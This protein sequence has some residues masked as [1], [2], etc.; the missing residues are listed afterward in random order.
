MERRK[1]AIA[2]GLAAL[3]IIVL[4]AVPVA[5]ISPPKNGEA[6]NLERQETSN[7]GCS[8]L[9]VAFIVDQSWAMEAPG[10]QEATDPLKQRKF[11]VDAMIDLL[12]G[13]S[14]DQCPGTHHR[15]T[16]VSYGSSV[17]TN[18]SLYDINPKTE[19]DAN[20]LRKEEGIKSRIKAENM[21]SGNNPEAAFNEVYRIWRTAPI[22]DD[23]DHVTKRVIVFLTNGISKKSPTD[24]A[25]GTESVKQQV[26]A[27]FPFD[28]VLLAREQCLNASR[29]EEG[30]VEE[31]AAAQCMANHMPANE[32][33]AYKNS[34]YIWTVFLKPPGYEKY[35]EAYQKIINHYDEMSKTHAGE[36]VELRA[37]SRKDIPTTFR[38]ILSYLAGVRPVLLNCGSFAMNPYLREARITVYKIDPEIKITLSYKDQDGVTHSIT[39]GK[40]DSDSAFRVKNYYTFGANEAYFLSYPYAGIWEL[41]ADNCQGLDTYYEQVQVNTSQKLSLP[42]II[43]QYEVEPFYDPEYPQ[44]LTYEMHD[45]ETGELILQANHPRFA[46]KTKADV[47][48]PTGETREYALKWDA[49]KKAFVASEPLWV[50]AAG[51]YNVHITGVSYAR[52]DKPS[53]LNTVVPELVFDK[54]FTLFEV[55]TQFEVG[56][57]V[58]F[59]IEIVQ[60]TGKFKNVH[61]LS[62]DRYPPLLVAP[63]TVQVR[64]LDRDKNM[65]PKPE[66]YLKSTQGVFTAYLEGGEKTAQVV[67][68][69]DPQNPGY[70]TGIAENFDAVGA[71]T[72][73]V[74]M[75][76]DAMLKDRRPYNREV[77]VEFERVD[78]LFHTP[79]FWNFLAYAFAVYL[80]GAAIVFFAVR[81]NKVNGT[82]AFED[83]S[84]LIAEFNLYSGKNWRDIKNRELKNQSQLGLKWMRISN[85]PR[86]KS[87]PVEGEFGLSNSETSQPGI[88]VRGARSDGSKFDF[89]LAPNLPTP[90]NESTI[91]MTYQPVNK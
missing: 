84:A 57:V 59:T 52:E 5:A 87:R 60:P 17:K 48:A 88:R 44:Y 63:M 91:T 13:L 77:E 76:P 69:P 20:E 29:D 32:A 33:E 22:I 78:D 75:N 38:K 8:N 71:Q 82:L 15:I 74:E 64:L 49:N 19:E 27:L 80:V 73:R 28:P 86:G 42:D 62:F 30:A 89:E 26:N 45:R 51:V 31:N 56:K 90:Y 7:Q 47:L 83:G 70:F 43:P 68:Q 23:D 21:G 54:L 2:I 61:R 67:L 50:A 34:V 46:V 25:L 55:K 79:P 18:L 37:N 3:L 16:V 81:T 58:P 35:G 4:A 11:A 10:T 36:A 41:T 65:L 85:A 24:Y 39:A 12:T 9:D 53:P 40:P 72:V 1:V 14:L 66:E 6:E